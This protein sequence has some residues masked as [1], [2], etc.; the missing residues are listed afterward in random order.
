MM[1]C[2]AGPVSWHAVEGVREER[3]VVG[4]VVL[5]L[6]VISV[7]AFAPRTG[8][9]GVELLGRWPDAM[10]IVQLS[11]GG[12]TQDFVRLTNISKAGLSLCFLFL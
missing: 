3:V 7:A 12:V 11:V 4:L 9:R 8:G 10:H 5:G 6:V 2:M 1:V